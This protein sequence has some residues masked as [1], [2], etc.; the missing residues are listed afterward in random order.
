MNVEP[1]EFVQLAI[2]AAGGSISGKTKL[3]KTIYFLGVL[4]DDLAELGYRPHYYGP[5]SG[6]V[7]QAVDHLRTIGVLEQETVEVGAVDCQGF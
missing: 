7:A 3:Q 2:M 6:V 1:Y 5:Y 4:T